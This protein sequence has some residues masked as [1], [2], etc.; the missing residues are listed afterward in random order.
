MKCIVRSLSVL[1]MVSVLA[2]P[3]HA[4]DQ[5]LAELV[6]E[7]LASNPD[8]AEARDR[9]LAR[10]DE[11]REAHGG[12]YPSVDLNAG[13]GY[14]YTDSPSTRG[15]SSQ[16]QDMTRKELG[17]NARQMIF[18]GWGTDNEVARQ[19]ARRSSAESRLYAV[20]EATAM[21]MVEAFV[22]LD[23]FH[24]LHRINAESLEIHRRIQ[25]QIRLRSEAGVG[26]R[27]DLDQ[28]DTRV[29]LAEVNLVAAAVNLED[30][31]TTFQRVIGWLPL[32]PASQPAR[33]AQG[34]L[35]A[36]LA[37]ALKTA[38]KG[39]P[40]LAVASADIDAAIAQHQAAK[41]F[42]YPRF[43][44]EVGGNLNDDISGVQ[45]HVDDLS[46][47]LRMRYNLYRGG[48]D[49]ARK[50]VTAHNIDEARDIR[51]RSYRQLEE[52]VRL[53]WSAYQATSKQLPLMRRQVDTANATR[54]AYEK[55]FNIGQRTL[56]DL[57]NSENELL[58][59]R[60][61]VAQTEADWFLAQY[62]LLEAMGTLVGHFGAAKALAGVAATQ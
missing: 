2:A 3:L 30:A 21:Q 28:V 6:Y 19:A 46:A 37:D 8:V 49:A 22:D 34:E 38:R 61:S 45:G 9:W 12:Y 33:L 4:R 42:D 15:R 11:Q 31:R 16:G 5:H 39:N 52:S 29:A 41:Q 55:Q 50:R 43:D 57:L 26:R 62:R 20:G 10:E 17:L 48:S 58:Q 35:P 24:T 14:E 51:D 36:S 59:A 32:G 53:A 1:A 18:D 40:V 25:D 7:A 13:I 60:Q 27:A 44:L 54:D 23:R 56:L 47:M